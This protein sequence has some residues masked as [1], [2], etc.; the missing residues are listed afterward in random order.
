MD[1]PASKSYSPLKSH[2]Y[3][4]KPGKRRTLCRHCITESLLP[5]NGSRERRGKCNIIANRIP[6]PSRQVY[7]VDRC[8]DAVPQSCSLLRCRPEGV[9]WL[10]S[11]PVA[12]Q[13][14]PE[15]LPE[16][17]E[18]HLALTQPPHR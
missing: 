17:K 1:P 13:E 2:S 15:A 11:Q 6:G 14:K 12:S 5:F 8:N 4:P 18:K 3:S 16:P 10:T 7:A 9:R